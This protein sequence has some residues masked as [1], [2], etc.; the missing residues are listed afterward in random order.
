[1]CFE[2][3]VYFRKAYDTVISFACALLFPYPLHQSFEQS[4]SFIIRIQHLNVGMH[5]ESKMHGIFIFN[6]CGYI[7]QVGNGAEVII[8]V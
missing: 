1:M 5:E 2:K 3:K 8:T 4:T 6:L 7:Q